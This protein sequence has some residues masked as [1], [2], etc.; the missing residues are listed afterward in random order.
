MLG[1]YL[2]C[3]LNCKFAD[4]EILFCSEVLRKLSIVRKRHKV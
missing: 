2:S 3:C 1:T 4:G